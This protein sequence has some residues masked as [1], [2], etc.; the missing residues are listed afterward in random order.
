MSLCPLVWRRL[1]VVVALSLIAA[2]CSTDLL[3]GGDE[4]DDAADDADSPGAD[5]GGGGDADGDDDSGEVVDDGAPDSGSELT[6]RSIRL[7]IGT[8]LSLIHI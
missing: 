7:A 5:T 1:L 4:P 2:G 6:T 8:N 3:Q